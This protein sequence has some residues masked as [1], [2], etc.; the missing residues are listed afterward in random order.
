ME[1][2]RPDQGAARRGR[3]VGED[4][5]KRPTLQRFVDEQIPRLQ[6]Y[7][8]YREMLAKQKDIDAVI[9]AT[10]DH[11]HAIIASAA[12]DVGKHVYVQKP[13]CW[14]VHEAQ[15][16]GEEGRGH[17]SRDADGQPAA[18]AGRRSAGSSTTSQGGAIGDVAEVH[19]WTNRPLGYWPQGIPRPAPAPEAARQGW[20]N[21]AVDQ[22]VA[23]AMAGNYPVRVHWPGI[24]FSASRRRCDYHPIY[25][26]F[27]WR[28]WVDWGAGALGDMGAHLIDFPMWALDLGLPTVIETEATPFNGASIRVRRRPTTSSPHGGTNR[29]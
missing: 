27:N 24:C 6:R 11:M 3:A 7:R 16:P 5:R 10:P 15:A 13:L 4:G 12:M 21:R 23:A 29:R 1:G 28:G 17:Q 26:P 20:D 22:R 19:V 14:S 25:H 18:L 8:D 2:F 9:V